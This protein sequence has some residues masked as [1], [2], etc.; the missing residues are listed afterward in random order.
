MQRSTGRLQ[1]SRWHLRRAI[2]TMNQH[3]EALGLTQ[4]PNKTEVVA[5]FR[6]SS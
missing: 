6:T 1:T 4:H 3:L 2:A 5:G